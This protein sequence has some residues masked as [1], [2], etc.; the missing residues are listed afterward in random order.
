MNVIL[1]VVKINDSIF[2]KNGKGKIKNMI[3]LNCYDNGE[4]VDVCLWDW[5]K[6]LNIKDIENKWF[7]FTALKF[8]NSFSTFSSTI[9]S[10]M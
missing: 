6:Q 8:S 4:L 2:V 3:R 1:F 9:Y 5:T 10:N 7:V